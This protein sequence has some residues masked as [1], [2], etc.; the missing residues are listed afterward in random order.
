MRAFERQ[1]L[2]VRLAID[3]AMFPFTLAKRSLSHPSLSMLI[4]LLPSADRPSILPNFMR[5]V[6]SCQRASAR[7]LIVC[8]HL[9]KVRL[10]PRLV[11]ACSASRSNANSFPPL[12]HMSVARPTRL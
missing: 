7:A 4:S 6:Y 2:Y 10:A 1:P 8:R 3:F 9:M 12:F 11:A 5:T